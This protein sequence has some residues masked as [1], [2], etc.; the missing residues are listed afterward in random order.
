[1]DMIKKTKIVDMCAERNEKIKAAEVM[2]EMASKIETYPT[3]L[4]ASSWRNFNEA[5]SKIDQGYWS[6]AMH[7][8]PMWSLMGSRQ[9]DTF[10]SQLDKDVPEFTEENLVATLLKLA[11]ESRE[12]LSKTVYDVFVNRSDS[13]KTNSAQ[14]IDKGIKYLNM[15]DHNCY[16]LRWRSE[17]TISDLERVVR[18]V[19]GQPP[20]ER[21]E[22]LTGLFRQHGENRRKRP[23]TDSVDLFDIKTWKNGNIHIKI[24]DDDVID[25]I[26]LILSGSIDQVAIPAF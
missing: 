5:R 18:I 7:L 20:N 26:N 17:G 22:G 14:K 10:R 8:T 9:R 4:F 12:I 25:K 21:H 6:K 15:F 19:S 2:Y 24:K 16:H 23:W 13:F 3:S 1:M 11:S